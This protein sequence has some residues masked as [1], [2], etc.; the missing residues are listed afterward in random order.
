MSVTVHLVCTLGLVLYL[1]WGSAGREL[2]PA[3]RI[4]I[5]YI[6]IQCIDNVIWP[7]L[8]KYRVLA[9]STWRLINKQTDR[10]FALVD[11]ID[12]FPGSGT[13][14]EFRCNRWNI[15]RM[16]CFNLLNYF[17]FLGNINWVII[18]VVH[19]FGITIST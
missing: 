2:G 11:Q 10:L 3:N 8:F 16:C 1:Y 5:H 15:W 12:R 9:F 13:L 14:W 4:L 6:Y 17:H 18:L 19:V 7:L